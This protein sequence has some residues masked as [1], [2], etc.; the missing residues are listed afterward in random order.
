L[1]LL[2]KLLSDD[3][4]IFISIDN[5]EVFNLKLICDEIFGVSN[6]IDCIAVIN[7]LKGRSDGKYIATAHE[8]LLI[9][10]AGGFITNG[11]PVPEEYDISSLNAVISVVLDKS[12]PP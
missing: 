12:S 8:N 11:V 9:Y 4:A 10:Q 3:G 6:F 7:N 1:R 2:Q 5:N